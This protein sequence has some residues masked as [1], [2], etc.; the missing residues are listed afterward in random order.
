MQ[1]QTRIATNTL[2]IFTATAVSGLFFFIYQITLARYLGANNFGVYSFAFAYAALFSY[3]IEG[4][5]GTLVIR[6]VSRH[7][8]LTANYLAG[9]LFNKAWLFALV[10]IGIA[11]TLSFLK[12]D[13]AV[14][15][16]IYL[17]LLASFF[18]SLANSFINIFK[19][20]EEMIYPGLYQIIKNLLIMNVALLSVYLEATLMNIVAM[21]TIAY[22][23]ALLFSIALYCKRFN[24]FARVDMKFSMGMMHSSL[25][26]CAY[27][28]LAIFYSKIDTILLSLFRG[29]IEVGFYN[30][31]YRL[32]EML[33]T[34][35]GVFL[36]AVFPSMAVAHL[37][38]RDT[39]R[40]I[41]KKVTQLLILF[42]LP[43]CIGATILSEEIVASLYGAEYLPSAPALMTLVWGS[44]FISLSAPCGGLLNATNNQRK[45]LFFISV[46]AVINPALNLLLIKR[47][48]YMGASY[49]ML[50]SEA[51]SFAI[52]FGFIYLY[53]LKIDLARLLI[54]PAVA[55]LI[56]GMFTVLMRGN[57]IMLIIPLSAC[58]YMLSLIALKA[59]S[60]EDI[61]TL[62]KILR[63]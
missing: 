61:L 40:L 5:L 45:N 16:L 63:M 56:M 18:E 52:S 28:A 11:A 26:L 31:S 9:S 36:S 29:N 19:A 37:E 20:H 15:G 23:L 50:I 55:G 42:I 39:L 21:Y 38:S 47:Y 17:F 8:E 10:F 13:G 32:I 58:I 59:F 30:A 51:I 53:I 34:A 24:L 27:G 7:K 1:L 60:R 46:I 62:K 25:A 48:G 43:V 57:S 2:I 14:E 49:T 35:P 41:Y 4:G 6:E 22:F 44:F 12:R 54:K 33:A 3:L